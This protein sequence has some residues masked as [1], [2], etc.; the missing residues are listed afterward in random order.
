MNYYCESLK[1]ETCLLLY[2]WVFK[3]EE[4]KRRDKKSSP[5]YVELIDEILPGHFAVCEEVR[6]RLNEEM[7][8]KLFLEVN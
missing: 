1:D 2:P 4:N 8:D 6:R 5:P 3:D 7:L